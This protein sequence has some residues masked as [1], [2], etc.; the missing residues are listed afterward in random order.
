MTDPALKIV[1]PAFLDKFRS[2]RPPAIAG[3]DTLL[4]PLKVLRVGGVDDFGRLHPSEEDY[5]TPELCFVSVPVH[6]EKNDMLHMIDEDIAVKYLPAKRIKRYRLALAS[7][8]ND[9]FFFCIVPSQ[10]LDNP[11]NKTALAGCAQAMTSWVRV[12]S[13]KAEG[14]DEYQINFAQD[15]DAFPEPKWPARTLNELLEVTFRGACIETENHP[16]LL[17][18]IG[19]KQDL[20]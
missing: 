3:V 20:K 19:A 12:D 18:M 7:K 11:Y 14:Y 1:K 15:Q 9:V 4:S 5:W 16:A 17:R 6:G 2:K 13:R 8:P 10:N